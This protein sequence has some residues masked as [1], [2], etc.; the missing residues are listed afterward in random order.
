MAPFKEYHQ[1]SNLAN[2]VHQIEELDDQIS[3]LG[4]LTED[5]CN[6]EWKDGATR[7]YEDPDK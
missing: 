2:V 7:P 6:E 5:L 4:P 3:N 1:T